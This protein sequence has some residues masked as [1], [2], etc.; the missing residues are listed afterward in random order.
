MGKTILIAE[1]GKA[2]RQALSF[3]LSNRG[4]D[5]VE[6]T[7]GTEALE[8][9]RALKPAAIILDSEMP[10]MSGYDVYRELKGDKNLRTI[11]VFVLV[12]DTDSFDIPTR[13][14]PPAGFLVSKPFTAH[15]LLQKV[16]KAVG[17]P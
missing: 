7:T 2:Q 15:D 4:F 3:I 13:T 11:P 10:G 17:P 9:A 12:A 1:D 14:I 8:K 6:A 5:V 16:E